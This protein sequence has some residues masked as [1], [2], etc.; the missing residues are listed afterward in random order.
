[1][2]PLKDDNP[3]TRTPFVTIALIIANIAIFFLVQP[4]SGSGAS[5][6]ESIEFSY[7]YAAVPC[8]LVNSRPLNGS[9]VDAA[10]NGNQDGCSGNDAPVCPNDLATAFCDND[11]FPNKN[12]YLSV[13]F[14][15]FLHGSIMHLGGNMLFL[16]VFGNNIEDHLGPIKFI[17]FYLFAGAVATAAHVAVQLD[18]VVPVIGASGAVAGVMG[19]YIVWF[20]KA[21]VLTLAFI[22]LT[23][24][25]AYAVLGFWFASQFFI[26][27][28][29]GIAWM[30]HVGGFLAGVLMALVVR[31]NPQARKTAWA[32][33]YVPVE[34]TSPEAASQMPW[35]NRNGG[36]S[37]PDG[38][39]WGHLEN[40]QPQSQS[41]SRS[42]FR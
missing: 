10:L 40:N 30:A 5:Q 11:V 13:V 37:G 21:R 8:E 39:P 7:E 35:D 4:Q 23:R 41:Q 34:R 6:T 42:R 1:V 22:I 25:P 33:K 19:A 26:G 36:I 24:I 29:E 31:K 18:S 2:F 17:I 3:T 14:S 9:E 12:V 15:M 28:D 16:W 20:P 27:P 38:S 32:D